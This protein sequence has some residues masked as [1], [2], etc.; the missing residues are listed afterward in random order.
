MKNVAENFE[1]KNVK[2]KFKHLLRMAMT[3][4]LIP[5][6]KKL[7]YNLYLVQNTKF[8]FLHQ[9]IIEILHT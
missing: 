9:N 3:N 5:I 7:Y 2:R 1:K 8:I 6:K 4:Q